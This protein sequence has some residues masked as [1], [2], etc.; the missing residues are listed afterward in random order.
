M[1]TAIKDSKSILTRLTKKYQQNSSKICA[2]MVVR[3]IEN[4]HFFAFL[5]F[6]I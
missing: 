1:P 3:E 2:K 5:A 4:A 6:I